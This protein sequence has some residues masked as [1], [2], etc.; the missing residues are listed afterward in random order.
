MRTGRWNSRQRSSQPGLH[1]GASRVRKRR[2]HARGGLAVRGQLDLAAALGLLEALGRE[3]EEPRTR[4]LGVLERDADRRA[5]QRNALPELLE[6]ALVRLVRLVVAQA[7]ELLEQLA[8][9]VG[10]AARNG[11][12]DEHAVVAAAEAL[13]H[14]H[15]VAAQRAHL[16]GLR[17]R[18]E[19]ELDRAV[20][21]L[22]RDRRAER[23]LDDRE[24]DLR[25]HVVALAHEPLVGPDAHRDVEVAR[26]AAER[27]R[28]ALAR[29][30]DALAVVDARPAPSTSS[31]RSSSVRPAPVHVSHG[32]LDLAP[33]ALAFGARRRADELAEEAPRDLLQPAVAA[34]ALAD[35]DVRARLDAV[36]VAG[37][38]R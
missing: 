26:A 9:L 4:L 15:A 3:L 10:E 6:E 7:L 2:E 35:R 25:E 16:A 22:D 31:D 13:E 36:A 11:D 24:V 18:L 37:A 30:A 20:E 21:R 29:E 33:G 23:G 8:L 28:V 27:A 5:D 34:A 32:M 14:R 12:V 17:A 19:L 1:L 38:R